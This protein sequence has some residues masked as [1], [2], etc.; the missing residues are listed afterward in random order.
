MVIGKKIKFNNKSNINNISINTQNFYNYSLHNNTNNNVINNNIIQDPN[1]PSKKFVRLL[2]FQ[3]L[4]IF[5]Q[6]LLVLVLK[7]MY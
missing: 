3:I 4:I 2:N 7:K 5:Y 6:Q 1:I